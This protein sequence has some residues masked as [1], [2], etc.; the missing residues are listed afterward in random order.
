MIPQGPPSDSSVFLQALGAH[1]ARLHP[2]VRRYV[3]G[4][5]D[6]VA[7]GDG[8]FTVAGSRHRWLMLLL[9]IIVGPDLLVSRYE[10]NVPFT[11]QN[12]GGTTAN[13]GPELH[14]RRSFYFRKGTQDFVDVLMPGSSS[15]SLR[16]LL[17]RARRLELELRCEATAHGSLRLTE[18]RAWFRVG[19]VRLRLPRF[20]SVQLDVEDGFNETLGRHTIDARVRSPLIGTVLEYR[21]TFAYHVDESASAPP[22][23]R[24][25]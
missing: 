21:G 11:V 24:A 12:R 7:T 3:E 2:R 18:G 19:P 10:R 13:G 22:C 23:T 14:A 16:N 4:P 6:G 20:L 9:R 5:G 8:V 1:A 17:G 15:G 25:R